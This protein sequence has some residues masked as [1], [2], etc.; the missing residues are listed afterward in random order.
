[1]SL[2]TIDDSKIFLYDRFPGE[3]NRNIGEPTGGFTGS[4]HHN[5]A[6]ATQY[7]V[8]TKIMVYDTTNKGYATFIYLQYVA[9]TVAGIAAKKPVAIHTAN[10]ASTTNA[11]TSVWYQVTTDGGESLVNGP[12]AIA[13]SSMTTLY[14]GW[15]WC[16]GVCPVSKVSGLGGNYTTDTS[17]AAGRPFTGADSSTGYIDLVVAGLGAAHATTSAD[18]MPAGFALKADA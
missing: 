13:L 11:T 5:V 16:G 8:G 10:Q 9:G 7:K 4:S 18:Y 6:S 17:V 2:S 12:L 3:V 15:F 14:Y 1:M